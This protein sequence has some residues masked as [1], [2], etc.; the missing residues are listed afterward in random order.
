MAS[1]VGEGNIAI[2][3]MAKNIYRPDKQSLAKS[4]WRGNREIEQFFRKSSD[5]S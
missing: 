2:F 5:F 3:T 4:R 1:P